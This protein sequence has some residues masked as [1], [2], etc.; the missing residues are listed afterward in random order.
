MPSSH[1]PVTEEVTPANPLTELVENMKPTF[2]PPISTDTMRCILL[3]D[4]QNHDPMMLLKTP[5]TSLLIGMGT[6]TLIVQGV[7]YP[8]FPDMRIV[9]SEKERISGWILTHIPENFELFKI[10]LDGLNFPPVYA[11]R[12]IIANI[13]D[14]LK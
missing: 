8:T 3:S 12:G 13:R 10:I 4:P 5:D 2:F 11:S 1:T 6:S 9:Y 7:E 14:N